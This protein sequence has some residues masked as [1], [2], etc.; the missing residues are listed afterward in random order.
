MTAAVHDGPSAIVPAV[1]TPG[2]LATVR[3]L[4]RH[5]VRTVVVSEHDSPPSFSSRYCDEK[6]SVPSPRSDLHS[7][8]DALLAL[9]G[10]DDVAAI[11]P[12]READVY[13]LA[14]HREAFAD[15]LGTP[16]PTFEKLRTVHDR[17]RLF[18][19]AD[20]A[21]VSAPET[22]RLDEVTDWTR[23]WI[24]KGR[25]AVLTAG[26]VE[27]VPEGRFESP[28]KTVFLDPGVEP[29]IESVTDRMGHVPIAQEFLDGT[30][31]CLRA[32]YRDGEPVA[33]SQK[34]LIRGYKYARGPSIYHEAVDLPGLEAAGTALLS[35]LEWE[36]LASVGFIESGGE[37]KLLEVNPR[38]PAS[39]PVDIHAGVDY[40]VRYWDL[41]RG[42]A[43]TSRDTYRSGTASHLLRGE[44]V[45]LH[46]IAFED[47]ALA[48]RPDLA[49]TALAVGLSV[50][51]NP[52]FDILSRDDPAPFVRDV[53]NLARSLLS[54]E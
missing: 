31:Y 19:A 51:R 7:Y 38:I 9:A 48:D 3:S 32:L 18:D 21:G 39:V 12:V 52:T 49:R 23:D 46:S 1:G 15:H 35:E 8:R 34:R 44:L 27:S 20:R 30:E 43:P 6:R 29:D 42:V 40:P 47:Y 37:F 26:T 14:A 13:V 10:R 50:V 28:P 22:C 36:G 11:V 45:H 33:T 25:Y 4:G 17:L 16:W 2:S 41:S 54:G 5:G 53:L 24:A